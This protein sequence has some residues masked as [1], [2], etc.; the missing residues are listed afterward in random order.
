VKKWI[1]ILALIAI[2]QHRAGLQRTAHGPPQFAQGEVV[3]Y[4]TATCGYCKLTR[5]LL[6]EHHVP[7]SDLNIETSAEARKRLVKISGGE[8][9][10]VL[11]VKNTTVFGYNK[12]HMLA[13]LY[14]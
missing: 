6:A 1:V 4:S 9:V 8:G 2:V 11:V 3:L 10:P 5:E 7:Y 12:E 13:V 14:Q